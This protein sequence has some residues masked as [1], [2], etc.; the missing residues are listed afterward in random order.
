M[1]TMPGRS[2]WRKR[3]NARTSGKRGIPAGSECRLTSRRCISGGQKASPSVFDIAQRPRWDSPARTSALNPCTGQ[4]LT[5][6][7]IAG[8][9]AAIADC[10]SVST[11]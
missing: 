2:P 10:V 11:D 9:A 5:V 3:P 8:A 4:R 7:V 1:T 6:W